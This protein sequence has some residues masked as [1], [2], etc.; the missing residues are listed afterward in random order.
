VA[1]EPAYGYSRPTPPP[2]VR[3]SLL[4]LAPFL[5]GGIV[6]IGVG[7]AR[8]VEAF[9]PTMAMED[10]IRFELPGMK[11]F[12]LDR[13]G[14]YSVVPDGDLLPPGIAFQLV[15]V[16]S[17]REI[18]LERHDFTEVFSGVEEEDNFEWLEFELGKPGTL[19]FTGKSP[20]DQSFVSDY[21]DVMSGSFA[22]LTKTI[23]IGLAIATG[24]F[25]FGLVGLIVVLVIRSGNRKKQY[26]ASY[27]QSILAK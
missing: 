17:G 14:R 2:K 13:P 23:L 5:V 20:G 3:P 6:V 8:M 25:L 26:Y 1:Q 11:T 18:E 19:Q 7:V 27:R 21:F 22:D 24:G 10:E 9:E 4:W 12:Q 16:E 15:H